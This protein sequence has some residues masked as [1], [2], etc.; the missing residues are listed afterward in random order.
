MH[1]AHKKSLERNR[2]Y[3]EIPTPLR[4]IDDNQ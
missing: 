3:K 4:S 2:A 1:F